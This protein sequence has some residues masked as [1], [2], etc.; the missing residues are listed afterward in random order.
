MRI[1]SLEHPRISDD[2]SCL[3]PGIE[4]GVR[5][6][7]DFE[8]TAE[9]RLA[10][11]GRI[12]RLVGADVARPFDTAQRIDRKIHEKIGNVRVSC[13]LQADDSTLRTL[14]AKPAQ[15][16]QV[17]TIGAHR[18]ARLRGGSVSDGSQ[19]DF[20]RMPVDGVMAEGVRRLQRY[21]RIVGG[22][23][24]RRC[25][26]HWVCP[27]WR[28]PG[29]SAPR[30]YANWRNV[31]IGSRSCLSAASRSLQCS[32]QVRVSPRTSSIALRA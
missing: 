6:T 26:D 27:T 12:A 31:S 2:I 7:P 8:L 15:L 22:D 19:P 16:G 23:A 4:H 11:E 9:R 30:R 1:H 29:M 24:R 13:P 10:A 25:R 5:V 20:R 32:F 17:E 28:S 21:S 14:F 18:L 3:V